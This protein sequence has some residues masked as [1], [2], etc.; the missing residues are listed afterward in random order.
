MDLESPAFYG[1]S[2]TSRCFYT[3]L[4][5][6]CAIVSLF[7]NVILI[8]TL[9]KPVMRSKSKRFLI[10]LAVSDCLVGLHC[11]WL[12]CYMLIDEIFLNKDVGYLDFVLMTFLTVS[13]ISSLAFIS[14]DRFCKLN[15]LTYETKISN[16][17]SK[18][19]VATAWVWPLIIQM[20]LTIG[21]YVTIFLL[22]STAISAAVMICICYSR[23]KQKIKTDTNTLNN[24]TQDEETKHLRLQKDKKLARRLHVLILAY[25]S[26]FLPILSSALIDV[27]SINVLN[28]NA[29][30]MVLQHLRFIGIFGIY[31]DSALNP[32]IHLAINT[33]MRKAAKA[34]ASFSILNR[35][36]TST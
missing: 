2:Y 27:I 4:V 23:I 31:M 29:N 24:S 9:R 7:G 10:S 21:F 5:G 8:M 18:L 12:T 32:I 22:M 33:K 13:S 28:L 6:F 1:L 17:K 34:T 14:Y 16:T 25:F 11:I 19:M 35:I 36:S 30:T 3:A 15:P 26:C 20:T